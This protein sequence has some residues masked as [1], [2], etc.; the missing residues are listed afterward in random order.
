MTPK[1]EPTQPEDGNLKIFY[2]VRSISPPPLRVRVPHRRQSENA[3]RLLADISASAPE[4]WPE[5]GEHRSISHSRGVVAAAIAHGARVGIDVEYMCPKRN[6]GAILEVFLGPMDK[7][8]SRVAFYRAWT[9]GEAYFK[10]FGRL[11]G[12]E[13]LARIVE[14]HVDDGLY[15][16]ERRE[17]AAVGVLHSKPFQNFSLSIVWEMADIASA[18]NQSPARILRGGLDGAGVTRLFAAPHHEN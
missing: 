15:R 3:R 5:M 10:A 18:T 12:A 6:T 4:P 17:N 8:V 14:H 13:S 9:F 7:P 11:P 16:I 2:G 1:D